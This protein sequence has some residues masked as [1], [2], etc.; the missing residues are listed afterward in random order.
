MLIA[1]SGYL[2]LAAVLGFQRDQAPAPRR[3]GPPDGTRRDPRH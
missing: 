3:T 1:S 2:V